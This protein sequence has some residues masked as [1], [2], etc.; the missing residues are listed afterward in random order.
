MIFLQIMVNLSSKFAIAI[1][2]R[3]EHTK[4]INL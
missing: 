1:E 4:Q 2:K 3:N